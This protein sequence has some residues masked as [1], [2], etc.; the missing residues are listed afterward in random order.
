VFDAFASVPARDDWIVIHS[1]QLRRHATQFQ[2]EADFIVLVPGRG[3]VV[4]ETKSPEY[5]TYR[6][7]EWVLDRVP[8]PGKSPFDQVDG[9]IRSLRAFLAKREILAGSE[10]IARL[11]WFTSLARHQFE[12]HGDMQFFEWELAFRDDLRRPDALIEKVLAEHDGWYRAVAGV[13]HDPAVMTA[14]HVATI[15]QALLGDL[16]G[17][18]TLAD[19]KL[20]RLDDEQRLLKSQGRILD[21]VA[22]N[23]R[24]YFEGPAGTGKSHLVMSAA[25]R[26][27]GEGARVLVVCWNELMADELRERLT[28]HTAIDATSLN[29]LML[30]IAG[31]DANPADADSGWYTERLPQ[32]AIDAL[33]A[34]RSRFAY[35]VV[36]I[37][38]FQDVA[39]LPGV[40]AFLDELVSDQTRLVL[41]GDARQQ[42]LRPSATHVDPFAVAREHFPGLMHVA[43]QL[44]V[45]QVAAL[46]SGAE[47]LLSRRFGYSGH[48]LVTNDPGALEIL[49]AGRD[50]ATAQVAHALRG[51]LEHHQAHDIV[52]LSPFGERHSLV[53]NLLS[54]P[55]FTKDEK[56]LRAQLRPL[57][58]SA[59]DASHGRVRWGSIGKFKG[60]DAEAV[61]LTDIGDR[62]INFAV[63]HGLSWFDLLYVGLTRARYRCVVVAG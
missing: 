50:N 22:R 42:I 54:A 23:D 29:A 45:R 19:R 12:T 38:E 34:D 3:I 49:P 7:G 2:G 41:A 63:Q 28:R 44:G 16:A 53:G 56:W 35:D 58:R 31:L 13:Q 20:E 18:R 8:N 6:D 61:I 30:R 27:A 43:V 10:P 36:C 33:R 26:R 11:V 25:K 55:N 9:A 60:L 62:G 39:G 32:L 57:V 21:A 40:L 4:V 59:A 5:V 14:D 48:R 46:A 17:G 15:A 24:L 47:Q 51:L 1:L 37:D 52:I